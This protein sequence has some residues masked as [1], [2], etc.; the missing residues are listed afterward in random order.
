MDELRFDFRLPEKPIRTKEM[1]IIPGWCFSSEKRIKR[2]YLVFGDVEFECNYG[3]INTSAAGHYDS[4]N[5]RDSGFACKLYSAKAGNIRISLKMEYAD[6]SIILYETSRC[7]MVLNGFD[8]ARIQGNK[9]ISAIHD[10]LKDIRLRIISKHLV[11]RTWLK[12][13]STRLYPKPV[14]KGAITIVCAANEN[15][16]LPLEVMIRSLLEN[17]RRYERVSIYILQ[18]DF[19]HK[20]RLKISACK[21]NIIWIDIKHDNPLFNHLKVS[22]HITLESYYRLFIPDLLPKATDKVIYLDCDIII[23]DDIG[24][25]WDTDIKDNYLMAVPEIQKDCLY[26]SSQH[27]LKLYK[28]LCIPEKTKLFNAGVLLINLKRWRQDNFAGKVIDYLVQEK[29]HVKLHDQDGLNA[30]AKG[31]WKELNPRWNLL[32]QIF[33]YSSWK[34]SPWSKRLYYRT[35]NN[36]AIIHYNHFAKPWHKNN[37]YYY[38]DL[39]YYYLDKTSWKGWRP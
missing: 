7:V 36:P 28:E 24:K 23:N 16:A 34:T 4:L 32:T 6:K 18:R 5:A 17:S 20:N 25:L 3:M 33:E 37:F 31:I 1:F 29:E 9:P 35:L 26:V 21:A 8:Y 27:G 13:L 10:M 11:F 22:D 15:F 39:F 19:S 2:L 12:H 14:T 30:M 38:N